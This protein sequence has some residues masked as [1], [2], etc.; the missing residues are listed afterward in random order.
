MA[1][2]KEVPYTEEDRYLAM[3]WETFADEVTKVTSEELLRRMLTR[4]RSQKNRHS[5]IYRIQQRIRKL[6]ANKAN[7]DLHDETSGGGL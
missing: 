7:E 1:R 3:S 2:K 6:A 5:H 4:E